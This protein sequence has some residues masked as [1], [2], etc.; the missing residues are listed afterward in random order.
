MGVAYDEVVPSQARGMPQF[1]IVHE[2]YAIVDEVLKPHGVIVRSYAPS[3]HRELPQELAKLRRGM[4]REVRDFAR[5]YGLLGYG[6]LVG[7]QGTGDPLLWIWT[8]AETL[9]LCLSL[10]DL[11]E[12]KEIGELREK[13]HA[14]ALP[15]PSP[16]GGQYWPAAVVAIQGEVISLAWGE[17]AFRAALRKM[18]G[19]APLPEDPLIE[20]DDDAHILD[21]ASSI[22]RDIINQNMAS[23]F[24]ILRS[25]EGRDQ[26]FYGF[27][28][29]IEVAY[30]H[31]ADRVIDGQ[32]QI[33]QEC[34]AYF[35]QTTKRQRFCPPRRGA[36]ESNCAIRHRVNKHLNKKRQTAQN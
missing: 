31:L 7:H 13:L 15:N 18:P 24:R 11:I 3:V 6:A 33:C 29:L 17:A 10:T 36:K 25:H 27:H 34:G 19:S 12:K 23:I 5:Q 21:L 22:R 20:Q 1:W 2:D 30:W 16:Q 14:L 35:F 9:R 28:A 32:V 26:S 8:H 4:T